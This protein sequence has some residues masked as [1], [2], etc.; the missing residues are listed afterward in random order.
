[1]KKSHTIFGI[2]TVSILAGTLLFPT[3]AWAATKASIQKTTYDGNGIV[4]IDFSRDVQY[5]NPKVTVKD[6]SG[7]TYKTS[8]RDKDE[9]D[10]EF[11]IKG[12][13][14]GK[15]YSYTISG[16]KGCGDSKYG[17]M[18]GKVSIPG[19]SAKACIAKAKYDK[20]GIIE[21]DFKTK[22]EYENA[23][24]VVRDSKGKAY[25]ASILDKDE[26]DLEFKI[27]NYKAGAAYTYTISGIRPKG[28]TSYSSVSGKVS[29]PAAEKVKVTL[30]QAKNIVL[31]H[32]K[33]TASD[34][35]FTKA[36]LD[37]SQGTP[38]YEIEFQYQ[39]MEYEYE[40][41]ATNGKILDWDKEIDD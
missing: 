16:I 2:L 19:A 40:I 33:L 20:N 10:L 13:A 6:S 15:T 27:K 24:I 1:M 30:E 7:R 14:K 31:K 38:S 21:I 12:F 4:E 25:T 17:N 41:H 9:D 28:A 11:S 22:V 8:I 18:S 23:K 39:N 3:A 32:A 34:V 29:I 5:K 36:T 37:K 35:N 26:D